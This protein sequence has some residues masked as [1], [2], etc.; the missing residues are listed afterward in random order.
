MTASTPIAA[1][2]A[3]QCQRHA[4]PCTRSGQVWLWRTQA[5]WC[6]NESS[7]CRQRKKSL[8]L[9]NHPS[10]QGRAARRCR[11][12]YC[13]VRSVYLD[14]GENAALSVTAGHGEPV[15]E[16]RET[17]SDHAR[18]MAASQAALERLT[19]RT[20]TLEATFEGG[21]NVVA[22]TRV[23]VPSWPQASDRIW[24]VTSARHRIS[25]SR[26]FNPAVRQ[27]DFCHGLVWCEKWQRR[28]SR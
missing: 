17:Y 14:A 12:L 21:P 1:N 13:A 7:N 15:Y 5:Q 22:G 10:F 19:S 24:S 9:G 23:R 18:A 6:E 4:R 27:A 28:V 11:R 3:L 8:T 16:H 25:A 2:A 26:A 20:A